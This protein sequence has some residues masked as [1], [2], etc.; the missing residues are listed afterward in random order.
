MATLEDA[1]EELALKL[2]EL[3]QEVEE[4]QGALAG[5]GETLDGDV[6]RIEEGWTALAARVDA[7]LGAVSEQAAGLQ[8]DVQRGGQALVDLQNAAAADQAEAAGAVSTAEEAAGELASWVSAQQDPLRQMTAEQV[9]A[10]LHDLR[11]RAGRAG[12][13][14]EEALDGARAFLEEEVP[15]ALA[16]AARQVRDAVQEACDGPLDQ[17]G[18]RLQESCD[19]WEAMIGAAFGA[20]LEGSFAAA[21]PHAREMVDWAL[22]E[23]TRGAGEALAQARDVALLVEQA[24][25]GLRDEVAALIAAHQQDGRQ[26]L[27]Q[28]HGELLQALADSARALDAVKSLLASFTFVRL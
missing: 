19:E 14:L 3:G 24:I 27:S 28:A 20:V 25:V 5:Y 22:G 21:P 18:A 2:K 7:F 12:A 26:R 8:E 13:A 9:E 10:A 16:A 4:G 23:C 11:E 15:A 17:A 6:K 1:A